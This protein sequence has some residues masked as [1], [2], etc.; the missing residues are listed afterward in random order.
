MAEMTTLERAL[1]IL[2]RLSTHD[3]VTVDD[4]YRVFEERESKRAIDRTLKAIENSNIPLE[5]SKG[6]HNTFHYTLRRGFDYT[7]QL[8]DPDEVIAA[9]LLAPFASTFAGSRIGDD[10]QGLFDKIRHLVPK[11]SVAMSSGFQGP[12][13]VIHIHN[14]GSPNPELSA[15][16][17]RLLFSAILERREIIVEYQSRADHVSLF[18][19]QPY[20]L[21]LHRGAMYSVVF[22]PKHKNFIYLALHRIQ[23]LNMAET[24]FNRDPEFNLKAVL[25]DNFGLW[26]EDPVDVRIR[27]NATVANTIRERT[28]HSSQTITELE[29]GRIELTMHVGPTEE[30]IAWILRWGTHAKLLEPVSLRAE[31]RD[32]LMEMLS[33]YD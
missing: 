5:I 18:R 28:W 27:F 23:K 30:L 17:L 25:A 8:L 31:L 4:L 33:A 9:M 7:P 19:A 24:I 6:P 29:E 11:D 16:I 22:V 12:Q 1:R 21:L 3:N 13:D 15:D 10:L 32:R 20:S 2:L 26:H 14:T